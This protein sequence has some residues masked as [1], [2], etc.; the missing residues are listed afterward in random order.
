[1]ISK[2][3]HILNYERREYQTE[4]VQDM[5]FSHYDVK[6]CGCALEEDTISYFTHFLYS[7]NALF[8]K[9]KMEILQVS[10]KTQF[11]PSTHFL[12]KLGSFLLH[13]SHAYGTPFSSHL[14]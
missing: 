7:L 12:D 11:P 10:Y 8:F 14:H 1:M 2:Y 4:I 5:P 6:I 13:G 3:S 9:N